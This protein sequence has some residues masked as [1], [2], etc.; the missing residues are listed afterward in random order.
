MKSPRRARRAR[1][2]A[3]VN[4]DLRVLGTRADGYHELRTV[5][6]TIE[7]HDT[8]TCIEQP[9]AVR[10]AAAARPA[11]RWT[12][13]IWCG[14]R[15]RALWKALGRAGEPRDTVVTLEKAIPMQAG[16][17]GG[18]ADAAAALAGAG[19][20]VGRR[21]GHAAARRRVRASAPTCRFSCRA[22]PRS[23]SAAARR[24][25]RSSIC[26]RTGSWSCGRRSA[27]RRP[28]RTPGT[29]RIARPG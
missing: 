13:P 11:C 2:H 20:A 4:L 27:C 29:T 24:S 28:K 1:A 12:T 8:L 22:A 26:R 15:R 23:G 7:L 21:A 10:A 18:S 25:I 19:A 16:L 14:G 17:G 6:Q 5:F 9:G 3:K